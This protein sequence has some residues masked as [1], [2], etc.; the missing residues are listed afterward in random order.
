MKH[1][2]WFCALLLLMAGC[3]PKSAAPDIGAPAIKS[4]AV[5][6]IVE[7]IAP[8]RRK[9]AIHHE[10]IPGYMPEMT[11]AFTVK[12]TN[13][14]K[15]ISPADEVA[16]LLFVGENDHWIENI[17]C[18][19]H[20]V[21][22]V[23]NGMFAFDTPRVA[24]GS[25]E[26]FPDGELLT[27]TGSRMRLS[28]FRGRAVAIT[29]FYTRCPLPDYC[30]RMNK[31]LA[32]ARDLILAAPQAPTNWQFLSISFDPQFDQPGILSSY[33]DAYRQS[34]SRHWLFA[35]ASAST[36]ADWTPRVNLII[37][38]EGAGI[39]HNLRTLVLDTQG[40]FYCQ[41]EGNQWT[42]QQLADAML[43]AAHGSSRF[44]PP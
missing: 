9:V 23:T 13:E 33:A 7:Q 37:F 27:E 44:A 17:R 10:T 42:P 8:D 11:M 19:G 15:N 38:H 41:F 39:S 40:R 28:D 24:S 1:L 29:F 5:R 18:L 4:Y 34:D 35:A 6:G 2:Y 21:G 30:P 22:N 3:K 32:A 26:T 25:G 12:D 20:H 31:N 43:G 36:L 14:L 16:F